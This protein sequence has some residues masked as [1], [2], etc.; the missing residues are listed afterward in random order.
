MSLSFLDRVTDANDTCDRSWHV[1]HDIEQR[2]VSV[3]LDNSLIQSRST[4]ETK[5]SCHFLAFEDLTREFGVTDRAGLA[6]GLGVTMRVA[7]LGE[8]PSFDRT[9]GSLTD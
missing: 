7:L 9:G 6:M 5:S 3:N 2:P 1:A 4:L 8:V